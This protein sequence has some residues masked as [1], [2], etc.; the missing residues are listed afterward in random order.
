MANKYKNAKLDLT[1]TNNTVLYTV[2]A[3]TVTI[4][5][6]IRVSNDSSSQDT[7]T[8]TITDTGDGVYSLVKL[9]NVDPLST[10]ELLSM[11]LIID[12]SEIIKCQ[13]TTANR[14][15]VIASFLEITRD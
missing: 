7:V 13:A 15:H 10:E 1:T 3:E 8:F 5:K 6:S 4:V 9:A 12:E 11:P 14:L 2:P